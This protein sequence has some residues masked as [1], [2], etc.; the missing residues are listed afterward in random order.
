MTA[1]SAYGFDRP[2]I[3]LGSPRAGTSILGR[4]LQAH[5]AF[6]H[7][8]EPRFIWRY[9]NDGRSDMFQARH[10]RP[11]VVAHIR[12]RFARILA[13][14]GGQRLLEKTPTNSLRVPFVEQVFPDAV[15]VHVMRNGYDCAAS[16]RSYWLNSTS[17]VANGRIGD[18]K[19]ILWQ[20]FAEAEPRQVPFY[21]W[22]LL[23]RLLPGRPGEPKTMWGPRLPGM[24]QMV[25]DMDL[26]EVAGLQWR[27]CVERGAID[28]R[29]LGPKRYMEIRLETLTLERVAEVLKHCGLDMVP[30]VEANFRAEFDSGKHLSRRTSLSAADRSAL[31]RVITPTMQWLGYDE[32]SGSSLAETQHAAPVAPIKETAP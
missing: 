6:V 4:L 26:I 8:K 18:K 13:E 20:R 25:R 27:E 2:V 10:A 24:A 17:G 30:E 3:I 29:A 31:R 32:P 5:P 19:S 14:G 11:E 28:G 16:I 15:Y 7:V 9:G 12:K 23:A 1:A 21:L 22:E